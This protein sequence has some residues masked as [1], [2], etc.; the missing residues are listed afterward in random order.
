MMALKKQDGFTSIYCT[1]QVISSDLLASLADYAGCHLFLH[2][3]DVLYANESFVAIHASSD[4]EKTI[5]FK[6]PCS[7]FEVYEKRSYGQAVDQ[8]TVNM[9][10]GETLMWYLGGE[11]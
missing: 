9:Q 4:G 7:P 3:D 1:A 5:R 10:R 6:A 8:I 11:F 2:G